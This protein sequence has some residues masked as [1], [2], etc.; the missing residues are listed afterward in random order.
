MSRDALVVGISS[1]RWL[2]DLGAPAND[3]EAIAQIL[4]S[5]GDFRVQRMPEIVKNNQ[6]QVGVT[7]PVTTAELEAALVKLFKPKGKNIPHTALFYYSGHGLQK[8]AGIQEGYLAT[9]DANPEAAVYGLSLF[10]LRRLLQESPVRQRIIILDCCHSGEILNCLEADPGAKSGTDR[11]FM[12]ASREYESAYESLEGNHSVFTQA[13]LDGLEPSTAANGTVTNYHLSDWVSN[14]L[15]SE[16]QQPLFENSGGEII[17]TRNQNAT[18]VLRTELSQDTC[19]YR[20]LEYFDESHASYFFGREDLTD[21][22]IDKLRTRNFVAIVGASGSGKSSLVR[23][24]LIHRLRLGHQFSGS[25]RWQIKILTPNDQPFKS[26]A[27]AFVNPKASA[28]ERAEQL[29]RAE[30][31]LN[32]GSGLSQLVR[33][34]LIPSDSDQTPDRML[35]VIDQFEEMFTLCQGVHADRDRHQFFNG[36][37]QTL[38]EL[39]DLLSVVI[40]LRADFFGKCSMYAGLAEKIEQN[41]ITVTPLTYDQIKSSIVKPA[42]KVGLTCDQN[43]TYNILRDIVGS[44]GEL[45]LLQYTLLELWHRRE[46]DPDGG[47]ARLTLNAY[48]EL[49]GVRGTLQKR[50]DEIFYSLAPD[51]QP[52]AKRI[53]IALTQLGDGT[54][55]TRRRILKSELV[56]PRFPAALV[57]RVIEKLVRAK[58]VVTNRTTPTNR[59]QERINQ[60]FANVSTALRFAQIR[61]GKI[62]RNAPASDTNFLGTVQAQ[63]AASYNLGIAKVTQLPGGHSSALPLPSTPGAPYQ[64][65]IDVA[66]E[67]L[68]RHWG[69]LCLWLD[70]NRDMLR[71]Q[72]K[73][74]QAARE[75]DSLNQPR[76]PEYTLRG[77]HLMDAEDFWATY[78]DELSAIAQKYIQVSRAESQR[79]HKELRLLQLSIPCTLL[80]ALVVT[81]NQYHSLVRSQTDKDYQIKVATSR[82]QA[83]IA[84]SILQDPNG[85]P[86][87]ALLISRLAVE[88]GEPTKEAQE[89][90]RAALQ[91]LRLQASLPGH[92]GPIR[93]VEFSTNQ[94]QIATAGDDGTIRIWSLKN[95]RVQY[96]LHWTDGPTEQTDS[97]LPSD[98]SGRLSAPTTAPTAV[99]TVTEMPPSPIVGMALS[100]D[101]QQIAAI[102][103]NANYVQVWSVAS[104]KMQL[105]LRGFKAATTKLAFS[106]RGDLI[107]AVSADN[108]VRIWQAQSGILQTQ[109]RYTAPIQALE[110]SPNGQFVLIASGSTLKLVQTKNGHTRSVM[111]HSSMITSARFSPNGQFIAAGGKDG[112][113]RIWRVKTAQ[114]FKTYV[115]GTRGVTQVLFSPDSTTLATTDQENQIRLWTVASGLIAKL[116]SKLDSKLDNVA[117]PEVDRGSGR[118]AIAFS[119]DSQKLVTP[120]STTVGPE[121]NHALRQWNA[122]TGQVL[123]T[124]PIEAGPIEI[125]RFSI[126]GSVIATA[127]SAG[128]TQLWSAQ[129]GSELPTLTTLGQ[130]SQWATFRRSQQDAPPPQGVDEVIALSL[131]GTWQRWHLFGSGALP[132]PQAK[133]HPEPIDS[134]LSPE[135]FKFKAQKLLQQVSYAIG[136]TRP[137]PLPESALS[138]GPAPRAENV[139]TA[140]NA[141]A[142]SVAVPRGPLPKNVLGQLTP[143]ATLTGVAFSGDVRQLAIADSQG[144][145]GLWT[146]NADWSLTLIHRLQSPSDGNM[147][148]T[149]QMAFS[150]DKSKVLGVGDDR[151]IRIWEVQSGKLVSSFSGHDAAISRAEFSPDGTCVVSAS[152]DRSARVWQVASGKEIHRFNHKAVVTSARFSPDG[153]MIVTASQDSAARVRDLNGGGYRVI[154]AGHHGAVLDA[155]F[156]P[157]GRMLVTASEDGTAKLWDAQTGTER[158]TLRPAESGQNPR[159]L[160]EAFFSADG[161]YVATLD[162]EGQLRTWVATWEGLVEVAQHRSLRQLQPEEC[163]RYLGLPANGC[164]VLP[165]VQ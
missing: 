83:A 147:H 52:I 36:L 131:N 1:Y 11:L 77:N 101:G 107:A 3:A 43:L 104:G 99:Q 140:E 106:P 59:Y 51:E 32:D 95:A 73:I 114:V 108:E 160:Q 117:M 145:M 158:S 78:S 142:N 156:S 88:Q 26:L 18:T 63:I 56:S 152:Y 157:D 29:R 4:Q 42:Q 161:R 45:P 19:P 68:I 133:R 153:Q 34:S 91:K 89:S 97:K 14:A 17:L 65:T 136:F 85:D 13:L 113:L 138:V 22:L 80:A 54:E 60:G 87:A 7:T 37:L 50:A 76:S 21:Q 122:K 115:Q 118:V 92:H 15:R 30:V 44:P 130:P 53:F 98:P 105:Q 35:L 86:T 155:A 46:A 96:E 124:F 71:R 103:K 84:Q 47:P 12:A 24:G 144:A 94:N 109:L 148:L 112:N 82:Q 164:P 16:V 162:G 146:L 67:A 20:G 49:G 64:E 100:P 74:E 61:R 79:S 58:L 129:G 132:F 135:A 39:G 125:V 40:V 127:G 150:A 141:P 149:R 123:E 126:D 70:E 116:D 159:P 69:L 143:G 75:W 66:H 81:L 62:P 25:D 111:H 163:L 120:T 134:P 110:F 41:L 137:K 38:D 6:T 31:F 8:D 139:P 55:D 9:S 102:A 121:M 23:A 27:N 154:L 165:N 48:T 57:E 10:W 2:P 72:R 5:Q 119:P 90:L 93:H 33:A 151:V 28:V 128:I